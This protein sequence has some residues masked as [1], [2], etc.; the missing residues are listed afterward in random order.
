MRSGPDRSVL[1]SQLPHESI[2]PRKGR[3]K[4]AIVY[5]SCRRGKVCPQRASNKTN[6][7]AINDMR[8]R[9]QTGMDQAIAKLTPSDLVYRAV[10]RPGV[11]ASS[12]CA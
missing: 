8:I 10:I 5:L 2:R 4:L 12:L 6:G 9:S 7:V 1:Q 11:R 3:E